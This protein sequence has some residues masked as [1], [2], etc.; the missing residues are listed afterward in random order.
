VEN[1]LGG[2]AKEGDVIIVRYE[3]PKGGPGMQEMLYPTSYVK[4]VGLS[5]QCALLTDGRFS[6]GSSGLCIGHVSAEAASGGAIGLI[7]NGDK[8][9]TDI[10][11]RF[12]DVVLSDGELELLR[13]KQDQLGWQPKEQRRRKVSTALKA[14]ALLATS[15]DMGAVR[16]ASKL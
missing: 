1:I 11:K 15:A 16:A 8:I 5:K 12:I 7:E 9:K 4:S 6:G 2:K 10:P 14:Y 13:A 3:G